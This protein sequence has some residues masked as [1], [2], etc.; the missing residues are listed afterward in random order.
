MTSHPT[1]ELP[2][3]FSFSKSN[4][5]H[6]IKGI[7]GEWTDHLLAM[8][9]PFVIWMHTELALVFVMAALPG[10]SSSVALFHSTPEAVH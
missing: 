1:E 5:Q 8:L 2:V 4:A 6:Q 3:L 7:L 9:V 10:N